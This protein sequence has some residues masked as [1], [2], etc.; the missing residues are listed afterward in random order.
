MRVRFDNLSLKLAKG[1]GGRVSGLGFKVSE[2]KI[3]VFWATGFKV[4]GSKA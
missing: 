4:N 3:K 2:S 1:L